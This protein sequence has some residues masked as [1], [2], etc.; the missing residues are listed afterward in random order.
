MTPDKKRRMVWDFIVGVILIIQML[1]IPVYVSFV[2]NIYQNDDVAI[3]MV[4]S[5]MEQIMIIFLFFDIILNFLTGFYHKG[6]YIDKKSKIAGNYLKTQFFLDLV[7]LIF[8]ILVFWKN[9]SK[10]FSVFFMINIVKIKKIFH[11]V[12][13]ALHLHVRFSSLLRLFKLAGLIIFLSHISACMWHMIAILE[14]SFNN[15]ILTWLHVYGQLNESTFSRYVYSFYYS[16]V[17]IVTV[18][19]GDIIPQNTTERIFSSLLILVGCGTFGYCISNLGSIFM[20]MSIEENKFNT[21]IAEIN[22]YMVKNNIN[23]NLQNKVRRYLEYLFNEEKEG[24]N[25]GLVVLQ[26]LSKSLKE[27]L[28]MDVYGKEIKNI[29]FLSLNFSENFLN[30]LILKFKEVSYGPEEIIFKV[31][32][33]FLIHLNFSLK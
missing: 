19:Y 17:T 7:P 13:E 2:E 27:E 24:D 9:Q 29:N 28:M 3:Y 18:G 6:V 23:F 21:K 26:S 12:E 25:K 10:F 15:N 5:L 33:I 8:L 31:K 22:D 30:A 14:I 11:K 32:N 20:E 16:I 4:T 1:Y